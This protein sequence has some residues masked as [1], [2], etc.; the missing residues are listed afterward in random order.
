MKSLKTSL[1]NRYSVNSFDRSYDSKI[2]SSNEPNGLMHMV[3]G[4]TNITRK[5]SLQ[6]YWKEDIPHDVKMTEIDNLLGKY[7]KRKS[8]FCAGDLIVRVQYAL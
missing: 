1:H 8:T 2:S 3:M 5:S 6:D 4:L 7:C